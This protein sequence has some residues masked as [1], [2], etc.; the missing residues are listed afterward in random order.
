M[1]IAR[2]LTESYWGTGKK[3]KKKI[4]LEPENLPIQ[5]SCFLELNPIRKDYLTFPETAK[6][7]KK[8]PSRMKGS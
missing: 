3:K 6:K 5:T 1:E 2:L 7:K 8:N 4:K